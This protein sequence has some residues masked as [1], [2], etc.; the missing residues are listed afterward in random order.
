MLVITPNGS[1][2]EGE[3]YSLSCDLMGDE[4]LDVTVS[5]IRWDRLTPTF[6]MGILREATLSFTP[7]T[8]AD[9]GDYNC[10]NTIT[11]PYLTST[12]TETQTETVSVNGK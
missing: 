5:S 8:V 10:T 7:L 4:S 6:K 1:P 11:S 2:I 3:T 9:A 12:R